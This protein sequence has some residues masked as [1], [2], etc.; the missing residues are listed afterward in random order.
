MQIYEKYRPRD[1]DSLVG[2]DKAVAVIDRLRDRGLAGRAYWIT[3]ASGTGKTSLARLIAGE[4]ADDFSVVE[5]DASELTPAKLA[6]AEDTLRYFGFGQ[7]NGRA[8]IV[9]EAHGLSASAIRQLLVALERIPGHCVWIFTATNEGNDLFEG[10]LD[11]SPL[12]SRCIEIALA[13]RDL[14][15]RFAIRAKEI[16]ETEGLDGRP[17]EDYVKLVRKQGNNFRRVLQEIDKGAMLPE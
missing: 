17:L 14:T 15:K 1:Y 10:K 2:Q 7:L 13:R 8:V 9:N 3:G 4:V 12:L 5:L 6:A 11:G 16:A